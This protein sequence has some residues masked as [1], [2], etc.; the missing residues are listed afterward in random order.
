MVNGDVVCAVQEYPSPNDVEYYY[1]D[2][3]DPA[4]KSRVDEDYG[5]NY[6]E[7]MKKAA[8][9]ASKETSQE[10]TTGQ[11]YMPEIRDYTLKTEF[12]DPFSAMPQVTITSKHC[13]F[14]APVL[15]YK[16]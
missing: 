5:E 11:A 8:A 9:S 6:D 10:S 1:D 14:L 3:H 13:C 12:H 16:A 7:E 2:K 15:P 4:L